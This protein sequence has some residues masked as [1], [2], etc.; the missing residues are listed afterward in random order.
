MVT[1]DLEGRI[2]P[3]AQLGSQWVSYDDIAEIRR[4]SNLIKQL[5]LGGG[6]VWALDLDDFRNSCGCGKHPLLKT[7]NH[8]LRGV[9]L[10]NQLEN[11]T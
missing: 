11:C 5:G 4:K 8:E 9:K 1:R 10:E 6:M 7:M 2:G 3:Y